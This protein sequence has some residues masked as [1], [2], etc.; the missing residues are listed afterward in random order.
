MGKGP[1]LFTDIGKKA[2]DLLTKDYTQDQKISIT[3][4]TES[5]LAFTSSGIKKG[6]TIICDVV[7]QFRD[8]N[9]TT[10]FKVDTNSNISTTVA[11]DDLA[12]GLKTI[13]SFTIPDKSSGK[14]ELQYHHDHAGIS[15]AVSLMAV[16]VVEVNGAF[17]S[18]EFALGGEFAFDTGSGAFTKYNA[19]IGITKPD[20]SAAVLLLD[21]GDTLK[22]S[23][24][25]SI[26]LVTKT[27]VAAEISHKFSTNENTFTVGSAY[28][29]D[30][31]TTVKTRLNNQGKFAALLQHE[32]RPKSTVTIST[33][34]DTKVLDRQAKVGLALALK[35]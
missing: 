4:Q 22:A 14:V 1:G 5:G 35:P 23:Y 31:L 19:G 10:D 26:S 27:S 2:K 28:A 20:F 9:V 11:V 24:L 25:H 7:T 8:R 33:E 12:P 18:P 32:W 15:S 16:P 17:G 6:D 21:K 34:L 3:T 13:F 30:P 29:L